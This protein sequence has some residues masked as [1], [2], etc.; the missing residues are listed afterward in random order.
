MSTTTCDYVS[1]RTGQ[2][3]KRCGRG[4]KVVSNRLIFIPDGPF[5]GQN[6]MRLHYCG[7]H[8]KFAHRTDYKCVR[9]ESVEAV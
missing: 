1:G 9:V 8:E 7:K 2:P 4:A 5:V 6:P 3:S